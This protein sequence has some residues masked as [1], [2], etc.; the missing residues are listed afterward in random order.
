LRN[1]PQATTGKAYSAFEDPPRIQKET[2]K[3][4]EDI[5][6]VI[7]PLPPLMEVIKFIDVEKVLRE[8]APGAYKWMPR[9]VVNWVKRKVHEDEINEKMTRNNHKFGL[10][11]NQAALDEFDVTV[12]ALHS[13]NVPLSGGIIVASNHPLGGLD[14]IALIQAVGKKRPDVR[15]LVNDI[16]RNL[17]NFG[18]L[19]VGVNKVGHTSRDGLNI[20]ESVYASDA[21]ILVFPAGLVSRKQEG[22]IEDLRWNKSFVSKAVKYQKDILPVYIEGRNSGFFYNL[23]I[24]RKRLG[25]KANIEMMLLPDELF[26]AKGKTIKI[27]FGKVIPYSTFNHSKSHQQWAD[28]LKEFIYSKEFQNNMSFSDYLNI[29]SR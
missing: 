5:N 12:E 19:F 17:K 2:Q 10:E 7:L 4:F 29:L 18:D 13:E 3:R 21:A 11:Y 22:K 14:G 23:S 8:K 1:A 27:H 25:V 9:F 26:K 16:L 6:R 15:F 20:I 24:W 28:R